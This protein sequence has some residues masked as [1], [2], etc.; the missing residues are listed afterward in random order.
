V[1]VGERVPI[2][3]ELLTVTMFA[4]APILE[5]PTIPGALLMQNE[6]RPLL[7]TENVDGESYTAQ[8]HELALFVM[9]PGIAQVPPFTVRFESPLRFGEKPVEHRL[10]TPALQ[11]EARMPPGAENLPGLIATRELRADQTWQPD[12]KKARVGDGFTRTVALTAP[13]VP[14]M[15]FPPFWARR[16]L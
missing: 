9:R 2:R 1:L 14:G 10:T 15:V 16:Q 5:L 11:V 7:S 4:S 8:Q 13:D 3:V 12:P 6:D